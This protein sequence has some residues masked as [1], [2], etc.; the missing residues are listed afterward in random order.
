MV[1]MVLIIVNIF[2]LI[3]KLMYFLGILVY[4]F[5]YKNIGSKIEFKIIDVSS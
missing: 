3:Y 4:C 2:D 1:W 5:L